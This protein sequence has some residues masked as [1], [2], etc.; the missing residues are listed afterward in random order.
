VQILSA[1]RALLRDICSRRGIRIAKWLGDGAMLVCVETPPLLAGIIELHHV[2]DA[3]SQPHQS[4]GIK[5]GTT[6]GDVILLEGDDYIGH[7]VNVAS[8]LCDV[9]R[10]GEALASAGVLEHLPAW[11]A[12]VE[13]K[14][15]QLRGVEHPLAV[16][17]LGFATLEG[18]VRPDPVCGIPLVEGVADSRLTRDDGGCLL[19]CS[20]SCRDTWEHRPGVMTPLTRAP[21]AA[22]PTNEFPTN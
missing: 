21:G 15:I 20:E 10:S 19:F 18:V 12:V 22:F 7:C 9:A 16:A 17:R 13:T 8:R 5:S 3:V 6:T 2:V 1:L 4:I 14:E 11:A